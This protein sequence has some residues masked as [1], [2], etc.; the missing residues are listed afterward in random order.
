MFR[1][2]FVVAVL[3]LSTLTA[4]CSAQSEPSTA[5][6]NLDDGRQVYIRYNAVSAKNDKAPNGKPWAPGGAPMTLFTEA[7]LSFGGVNH[8]RRRLH[9]LSHPRQR[10]DF[11]RQQ[12]RNPRLRLRRKAGRRPLPHGNRPGIPAFRCPR[13]SLRPRRRKMHPPHLLRQNRLLRPLHRQIATP[14]AVPSEY[15]GVCGPRSDASGVDGLPWILL[16]EAMLALHR[17][18]IRSRHIHSETIPHA[19]L[20]RPL[21][22][23]ALAQSARKLKLPTPLKI[24][25]A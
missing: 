15:C 10:V 4:I 13:S 24:S 2:R 22:A 1:A 23:T 7:Q 9:R 14:N 21:A 12:E 11:S 17:E 6:C 3:S 8:P 19:H 20:A 5:S 16:S 25:A 18:S